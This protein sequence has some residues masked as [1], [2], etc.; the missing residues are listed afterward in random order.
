VIFPGTYLTR[1][2]CTDVAYVNPPASPRVSPVRQKHVSHRRATGHQTWS[3][4]RDLIEIIIGISLYSHLSHFDICLRS[5]VKE[6]TAINTSI[7]LVGLL[8]SVSWYRENY[9]GLVLVLSDMTRLWGRQFRK[10]DPILIARSKTSQ[11]EREDLLPDR[12]DLKSWMAE[13]IADDSLYI[14]WSATP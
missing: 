14:C 13:K 8:H 2:D 5:S 12:K 9:P 6:I 11:R 7:L 1:Q 10:K 3:R 4:R